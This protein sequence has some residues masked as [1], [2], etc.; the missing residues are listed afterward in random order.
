MAGYV[1]HLE[2]GDALDATRYFQGPWK[3][4]ERRAL[5]PDTGVT[6]AATE[7]EYAIIVT[8]GNGEYTVG[9]KVGPA[10]EGSS[11]TVGYG[12]IIALTAGAGGLELFITSLAVPAR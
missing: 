6:F 12:A 3:Q 11:F 2:P 1:G 8:A 9:D 5:A 7:D 10:T 4:F